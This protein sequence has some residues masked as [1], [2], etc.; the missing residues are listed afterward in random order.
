MTFLFDFFFVPGSHS[1]KASTCHKTHLSLFHQYVPGHRS[2]VSP[3][4]NMRCVAVDT[5]RAWE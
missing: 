5:I 1:I 2:N 3:A 4:A